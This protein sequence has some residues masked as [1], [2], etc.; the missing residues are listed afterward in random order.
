[1]KII[2]NSIKNISD[3]FLSFSEELDGCNYV[4]VIEARKFCFIENENFE[5]DAFF[6]IDNIKCLFPEYAD[7]RGRIAKENWD[8]F[9][10]KINKL[11]RY[12]TLD[13]GHVASDEFLN[14]ISLQALE[15]RV[16]SLLSILKK[17]MFI[18]A[19]SVYFYEP[20]PSWENELYD[21]VMWLLNYIL[22]DEK[23]KTGIYI[24]MAAFD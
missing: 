16:S 12:T 15:K 6:S 2:N 5:E 9:L 17:H 23:N 10:K 21:F 3:N 14:L 7:I 4:V 22:I 24:Y 8:V 11:L 20:A 1:M 13:T 18:P 19:D